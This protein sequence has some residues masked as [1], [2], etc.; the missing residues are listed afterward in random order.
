MKRRYFACCLV[1]ELVILV[2]F[3]SHLGTVLP[4]QLSMFTGSAVMSAKFT[5]SILLPAALYLIAIHVVAIGLVSLV[6]VMQAKTSPVAHLGA[7]LLPVLSGYLEIFSVVLMLYFFDL[8]VKGLL[9][10]MASFSLLA[11]VLVSVIVW[12][13]SLRS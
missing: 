4:M 7:S 9:L 6:P 10:S 13:K 2:L 8:P 12:I 1:V 11:V 5:G 3:R